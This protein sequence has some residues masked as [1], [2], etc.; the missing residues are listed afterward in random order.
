M[1]K[2]IYGKSGSGKSS[3][4]YEDIKK[5][6][7]K[8]KIFLIVPEQ[9]NLNS[10]QKLFK[11]LQK[12]SLLNI[13]VLTLSRMAVRILEDVGR[14]DFTTIDNSSKSMIIYDIL[15]REKDKLNFLGKSDNNIKIISKMITELKKHNINFEML[16]EC[17]L[18][19]ILTKLKIEDIKLIYQKYQEILHG[20]FVDENDILSI[21]SPKILESNFFENSFVYI[22]DFYGFTPQEYDVFENILKKSDKITVS[23]TCD[24]LNP[25]EK[26]NDIFYFNKVFVN[27]LIKIATDNKFDVEKV[28]LKENF[29]AKV[30]EIK[31]LEKAFSS[32]IPVKLYDN[33]PENV[34]LFLANNSYSELEY[35]ANEILK[36]VKEENY[37]YNEIAIISD[38]LDTYNLEAKIIFDK[39]D[40]PIFIDNKKDL[41][42]NLLIKYILSVIDIFVKIL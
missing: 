1:L 41:S 34:K 6:I 25:L 42:E 3:Y 30:D 8:E 24:N 36:L 13:Q 17:E 26:E 39:Y 21:V 15:L 2:I 22:D 19:D 12:D 31:Y 29:R 32:Y 28:Y 14:N 37:N 4:L 35:V 10:E 18:K 7:D 11:Y 9:S 33:I 40:I 20:N 16:D 23:I 38:D 27:K 5:N